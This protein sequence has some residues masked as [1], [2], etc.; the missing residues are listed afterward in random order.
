MFTKTATINLVALA[1]GEFDGSM[2]KFTKTAAKKLASIYRDSPIK[3]DIGGMLN[4]VAN[5]YNISSDPKDY[6]FEAARAVTAEESNLN[7]DAFPRTELLRFDHRLGKAVY[8]T[9]IGKPHHINHRADDPKT[10]RGVVLDASYNDLSLPLDKC[11]GCGGKTAEVESRDSTGINC[12]KC[13]HCVKDEFVEL[14]IAIDRSKDATFANGVKSGNL[15]SLSMGCFLAGT[16][17]TMSDGVVKPIEQIAIGDKVLTHTGKTA[18]VKELSK[19]NYDGMTYSFKVAGLPDVITATAE[20]PVWSPD[21]EWIHASHLTD[22]ITLLSPRLDSDI[23]TYVDPS[24]ARMAGFFVAEGSYIYGYDVSNL[25]KRVGLEWSFGPNEDTYADEVVAYITKYG[26]TASKYKRIDRPGTIVKSYR[27]ENLT[28]KMFKLVGE[29]CDQKHLS[30]E[31]F[32][33]PVDCQMQFIGAWIDGDGCYS[34]HGKKATKHTTVTTTSI[35][36]QHQLSQL[37][38][39][40]NIPHSLQDRQHTSGFGSEKP[41]LDVV[42]RGDWQMPFNKVSNKVKRSKLG[43]WSLTKQSDRGIIRP[44]TDVVEQEYVG[45]VYNFEVD[46]PDHSYVAGGIAVHNCEA[47]YT[48]CSICNNRARSISQFCQHIKSGN[49]KKIFKTA[50]GPKMAY[51]R[52]GDVV[53]TEISRVDQPADPKALQSEIFSMH[54][55]TGDASLFMLAERVNKI[56]A[57]LFKG[58][59]LLDNDIGECD[60]ILQKIEEIKT[61]HSDLY[62]EL[63]KML[64]P[65]S[66]D[67][68]DPMSIDDYGKKRQDAMDK[69][70]TP[71]ELGIK[72]EMGGNLPST[73]ANRIASEIDSEFKDLLKKTNRSEEIKVNTLKFAKSYSELEASVTSKGNIRIFTPKG[74]L[75]VVRPA[76]KPTDAASSKKI[77]TEILTSVAE[78]GLVETVQKYNAVLSPKMSQVLEFHIEDFVD[79]REEGDKKPI[80]DKLVVDFTP[81]RESPSKNL[82]EGGER[83]H[84]ESLGKPADSVTKDIAL[85][86]QEKPGK[87]DSVLTQEISDMNEARGKPSKDTL[88][89]VVVDRSDKLPKTSA[90]KSKKQV[91]PEFKMRGKKCVKCEKFECDGKCESKKEA[92]AVQTQMSPMP[93]VQPVQPPPPAAS[94]GQPVTAEEDEQVKKYVSRLERLYASRL[95]KVQAEAKI[96]VDAAEATA[97]KKL[98]AKF[99]RAIKLAARRQALNLETS[100]L[101]ARMFD[102]LANRMDLDSE[103]FYPGMDEYTASK[104]VE[105]TTAGAFNDFVDSLM[106]RAVELSAMSDETFKAIEADVNNLRPVPVV[107]QAS[108]N[109]VAAREDV[110]QAAIDGNMI[111]APSAN[112]EV[113]SSGGKRDNI[114]SALDTTKVRRTGQALLNK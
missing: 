90:E 17:I 91:S 15:N 106:K 100:P 6:I 5:E 49:K 96:K 104:L 27:C 12:I 39:N 81:G 31:I 14:L 20:H 21:L 102:I 105:A 50:S 59:Q 52:C 101:K 51:E 63:K 25:G 61:T 85:D 76:T 67:V 64:D 92:Q 58:A 7:G 86:H 40:L 94:P 60:D 84:T 68:P 111:V 75:F 114:R 11:P 98:E 38:T 13:G 56:E 108:M 36:L 53:F 10:S 93:G 89:D 16:K 65:G 78:N 45:D 62:R 33:W 22:G 30:D 24:F 87:S 103:S 112:S 71:A 4:L 88:K 57:K 19:R 107:V 55:P 47:G 46:H 26:L 35:D 95:S 8:Q 9:F 48:D 42:I 113:I 18:L 43:T 83:D 69:M 44:V 110:R 77:A 3:I 72:P 70:V 2:V 74:S 29:Y 41:A 79:G 97:V 34:S 1:T 54:I 80:T 23:T 66:A 109:K 32:T 99:T 82:Q 28:D 73:I 37:L